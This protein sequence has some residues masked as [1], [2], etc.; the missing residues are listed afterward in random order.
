MA[1]DVWQSDANGTPDAV[2][3]TG[4]LPVQGSSAQGER[5]HR[6][7]HGP[8]DDGAARSIHSAQAFTQSATPLVSLASITTSLMACPP[9]LTVENAQGPISGPWPW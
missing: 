4:C 7:T 5:E 8:H 1:K 3:V 2:E 9:L 6:G